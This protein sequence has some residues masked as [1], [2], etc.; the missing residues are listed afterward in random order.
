MMH[1][2]VGEGIA[3]ADSRVKGTGESYFGCILPDSVNIDG[4]A[5]KNM[6]WAAHLRAK[7][8]RA[9]YENVGRFYAENRKRYDSDYLFGYCIHCI[10][11]AAFDEFF[12][13]GIWERAKTLTYPEHSGMGPGWDECFRFDRTVMDGFW[14]NEKIKPLLEKTVPTGIGRVSAELAGRWLKYTLNN[15]Y[16]TLPPEPPTFVTVEVIEELILKTLNKTEEYL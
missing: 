15:Y 4:F 10:T 13:D 2:L 1:L 9:W 5:P 12:H 6:R 7:T 3:K 8:P 16:A 11:D 14:W